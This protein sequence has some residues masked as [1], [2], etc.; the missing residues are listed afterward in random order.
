MTIQ[1]QNIQPG[2]YSNFFKY[3]EEEVTGFGVDYDYNSAMHYSRSGFS[4][5]GEDTITPL[6][7]KED[8]TL[9][10]S[11]ISIFI[12]FAGSQCRDWTACGAQRGGPGKGSEDVQLLVD[13]MPINECLL[14]ID[15][16]LFTNL[17][18]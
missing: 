13:G 10:K 17:V 11:V 16:A 7:R 3:T 8:V 2:Y 14:I 5:N 6:V 18:A 15:R 9:I 1:W 4:I 12:I